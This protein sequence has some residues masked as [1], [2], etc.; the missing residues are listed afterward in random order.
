[1]LII[2][3]SLNPR[4]AAELNKRG[5]N[6]RSVASLGYRG[7]KDPELIYALVADYPEAILV[8]ADDQM[9]AVHA[10]VL[11]ATKVTIATVSP[12]R[13]A[14]YSPEQWERE[15]VHRWAHKMEVQ[16]RGSIR[17]YTLVGGRVWRVRKRPAEIQDDPR[18]ADAAEDRSTELGAT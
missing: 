15:I 5:R 6:A 16:A 4:I 1:M 7:L 12:E 11:R 2:D 13:A 9:P 10:D 17:R 3:E 14:G 18:T 8:T